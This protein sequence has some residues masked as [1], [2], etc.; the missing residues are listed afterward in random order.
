[1]IRLAEN[2]ISSASCEFPECAWLSLYLCHS[3]VLYFCCVVPYVFKSLLITSCFL[4]YPILRLLS[5]SAVLEL[6]LKRTAFRKSLGL[7]TLNLCNI[8]HGWG[9][10][11]SYRLWH[12]FVIHF[13][14]E[15]SGSGVMKGAAVGWGF[16]WHSW[17]RDTECAFDVSNGFWLIIDLAHTTYNYIL[18]AQIF[19]WTH[20][21]VDTTVISK[22]WYRGLSYSVTLRRF[23]RYELNNLLVD[24]SQRFHKI[25]EVLQMEIRE[26]D[27]KNHPI[28]KLRKSPRMCQTMLVLPH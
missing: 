27:L 18:L 12:G 26:S 16:S 10:V 17:F 3:L 28:I 9:R 22:I 20:F 8:V 1:M 2:S 24:N 25:N 23:R 11:C 7:A 19:T 15:V 21:K 6:Y 4:G 13:V 5:P 14:S